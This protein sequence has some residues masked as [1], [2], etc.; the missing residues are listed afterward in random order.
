MSIKIKI[1]RKR[2]FIIIIN[3]DDDTITIDTTTKTNINEN[4]YSWSLSN[5]KRLTDYY[6]IKHPIDGTEIF[7][8]DNMIAYIVYKYQDIIILYTNEDNKIVPMSMGFDWEMVNDLVRINASGLSVNENGMCEE[9]N[10]NFIKRNDKTFYPFD[11]LMRN[12]GK[13]ICDKIQNNCK[14]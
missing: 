10:M 14:D 9:I 4:M 6:I 8:N 12:I 2:S 1:L 11:M 7:D 5:Q 3:N 13:S